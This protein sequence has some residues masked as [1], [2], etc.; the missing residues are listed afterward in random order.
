MMLKR[1]E[2]TLNASIWLHGRLLQTSKSEVLL[3]Y[4]MSEKEKERWLYSFLPC[5]RCFGNCRP[6]EAN[7]EEKDNEREEGK[8]VEKYSSKNVVSSLLSS[9]LFLS[10]HLAN[11]VN[12]LL[13]FSP[14]FVRCLLQNPLVG[15]KGNAR[16]S[17]RASKPKTIIIANLPSARGDCYVAGERKRKRGG[18]TVT[19]KRTR[20]EREKMLKG[21]EKAGRRRRQR[22]EE[23]A[24]SKGGRL[25]SQ[26]VSYFR[27][28]FVRSVRIKLQF[29][30]N[31]IIVFLFFCLFFHFCLFFPPILNHCLP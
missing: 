29:G 28:S 11:F 15:Q 21:E 26:P 6:A 19:I 4:E 31:V 24:S 9:S 18:E 16:A 17:E 13:P 23:T 2:E 27:R 22:K 1:N 30:E 12:R 10:F 25:A 5:L 20:R 7:R 14:H 8:S 3:L